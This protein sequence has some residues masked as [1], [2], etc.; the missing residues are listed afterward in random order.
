MTFAQRAVLAIAIALVSA[1]SHASDLA[2][3]AENTSPLELGAGLSHVYLFVRLLGDANL[4]VQSRVSI[5]AVFS[6]RLDSI[7]RLLVHNGL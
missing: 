5:T 3:V 6:V 2:V 1:S 4:D 7:L